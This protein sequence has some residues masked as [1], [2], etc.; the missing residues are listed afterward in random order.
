MSE[1]FESVLVKVTSVEITDVNPDAPSN[2][3]EWVIDDGT[4][5]LRVDDRGSYTFSTTDDTSP[6]FLPLGTTIESLTGVLDFSFSNFKLQP[7]DNNDFQGIVTDVDELDSNVPESF[8][9]FQNYPN[10]FNPETTI[11]YRLPSAQE[12]QLK[13]YNILGQQ[14]KLLLDK[15]QLAGD[16]KVVWDGKDDRGNLMP[17]GVYIYR[18]QAGDFEKS[19]KMILLK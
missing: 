6:D 1:S 15:Q 5:P 8:T 19:N 13:I 16:Y 18:I 4:G 10:P 7:R 17:S 2:F 12:V 14:V 11:R 3:G 9:L